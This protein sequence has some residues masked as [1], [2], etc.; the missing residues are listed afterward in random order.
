MKPY[1]FYV[2]LGKYKRKNITPA[3]YERLQQGMKQSRS[4]RY[5]FY[6]STG[7][8]DPKYLVGGSNEP[9]PK[10]ERAK[11]SQ[12]TAP[13]FQSIHAGTRFR[14]VRGK[15]IKHR[16]F[17][18]TKDLARNH[19]GLMVGSGVVLALVLVIVGHQAA[20]KSSEMADSEIR[21]MELNPEP[22]QL[23]SSRSMPGLD[24]ITAESILSDADRLL[25]I[26]QESFKE[27]LAAEV[28]PEEAKRAEES[29][30][31]QS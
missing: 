31:D 1:E 22:D 10:I 13:Q 8:M 20:P 27:T 28:L 9:S 29:G 16:W 6:S 3:E 25:M 5:T 23:A 19:I 12:E 17:R 7:E 2:L 26:D 24:T 4:F 30:S 11:E 14:R 21:V 18:L 15:R